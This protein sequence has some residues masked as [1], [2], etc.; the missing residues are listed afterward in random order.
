MK[1]EYQRIIRVAALSL[2][3][4]FLFGMHV[5]AEEMEA[6]P[7]RVY[8]V[9][10]ENGNV[11]EAEPEVGTVEGVG[12]AQEP[13]ISAYSEDGQVETYAA[14]Q[15]VN[16]N[17]KGNAVTQY[18]ENVTGA[19]GY[20]NGACGADAA[21]LG[22]SGGKVKFMLS[23]VVGLVNASEVQVVNRSQISSVS[24]YS[25]RNG[26]LYHYIT[27]NVNG[28]GSNS[29]INQGTAPGYLQGG[30]TYYSYD[31]H[32]FYTNYG[33]MLGDYQGGTRANAV[34]AG[35]P[36][37]NYFQYLPL[38][39]TSSYNGSDLDGLISSRGV[40]AGSKMLN[41]GNA[42]YDNQNLYG[43]NA[44]ISLG[45]S[46]NES[47]WGTS[48]LAI[49][50]NNLFGLNA[51]DSNPN[52]ASYYSSPAD[53][54]RQFMETWMSK[55]YLNPTN[56][57]Y[58]G[59]FLGNK[60]SG[61]NV[62]YA[63]DPYWG[64]KAASVA[65]ILDEYGGS[66]DAN[67]YTIAMKGMIGDD[68]FGKISMYSE[69]S[70]S[71]ALIYQGDTQRESS[72]I[73]INNSPVNGF[74]KVQSSAVL[75]SNRQSMNGASGGYNFASMH[76]Y[77]GTNALTVVS[78][79]INQTVATQCWDV[80]TTDWYYSAAQYMYDTLIMT[81][82]NGSY[83]GATE[84]MSRAQFAVT[85]YRMEGSPAAGNA[86]Q[87]PDVGAGAFYTDAVSWATNNNII[88]GYENGHFGTSDQITREQL[89]T[90]L[91]RYANYKG[92][93]TSDTNDLSGFPDKEN[94]SEFAQQ[95]IQ[96]AVGAGII[97]G[98]GG[99]INPSASASRAHVAMMLMRFRE[100]Y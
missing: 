29:V 5:Q 66:K 100:K 10:D 57:T 75:T 62:K 55:W 61:M 33:T 77:I 73:L 67:R 45:I 13:E 14:E 36:F 51:V 22:T 4:T 56:S 15:V 68:I 20:T 50:R 48:N 63:S 71:S 72:Y 17:T 25:V 28:Q 9:M 78:Q 97:S 38:R 82:M 24:Y 1:K 26:I 12:E 40:S 31:G 37:Y 43:V 91:Y 93:A 41:S 81:G 35:T 18:T 94:V 32:Y 6:V 86:A 79:G 92:Y 11:Y 85:L 16:L 98:D 39:S 59:G 42:F 27:T 60:A 69:A 8:T 99:K 70:T 80:S 89:A 76:W 52:G 83:Y 90:L 7:D 74:Y 47:A 34:N 58:S 87:Y 88:A 19:S 65:R 54:V 96:W 30:V 21:Y 46:A 49:S 84:N 2:M 95:A 44:L 23:G 64:E 53:C 3:S